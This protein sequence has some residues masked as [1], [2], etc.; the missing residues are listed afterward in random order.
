MVPLHF[1]IVIA[2]HCAL[3][4]AERCIESVL[5]QVGDY[6]I[7]LFYR[8][9][10]SGYS[11][12]DLLY[13]RKL[14]ET[15]GG[16]FIDGKGRQYQIGSLD[17]MMRQID[18]PQTIVCELDGD[19]YLLPHALRV[20]SEAY[21]D[22]LVALTYGNT[23][24]DFRPYQDWHYF[25]R[26]KCYTNTSFPQEVW[27][28]GSF[29]QDEFRCFHLRTFRRWLWD[30]IDPQHFRRADGSFF[31]GSGDSAFMYPMIEMLAEPQHVRFI[32]EP[33][34]VYRLHENNVWRTDKP[35]QAND[36]AYIRSLRPYSP[37]DRVILQRLLSSEEL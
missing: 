24:V 21:S 2:A 7:D 8:D 32:E 5:W 36:F 1:A 23:L 19:D 15:A 34:Y 25:G 10:A 27:R 6:Q 14:V 26:D 29:R 35:S 31:R 9:D 12:D 37:I 30:R 33:I 28:Q 20:V 22:P 11:E 13:L 17:T 18:D 3:H 4:F 16:T